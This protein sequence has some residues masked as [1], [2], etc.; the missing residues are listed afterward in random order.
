MLEKIAVGKEIKMHEVV[1]HLVINNLIYLIAVVVYLRVLIK[2]KRII[3]WE[4]APADTRNMI[5]RHEKRINFILKIIIGVG[6]IFGL[7]YS[8]IPFVM[9]IGNIMNQ[10][11]YV[12]EGEVESWNYSD[13]G[14]IE[15]RGVGILC[16][17]T[18]KEI[19]VVI[20]DTGVRK[21]EY[22]RVRY[23]PHTKQGEIM[24]RREMKNE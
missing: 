9:D 23:L 11:Y 5:K 13:E 20:Y 6:V 24:Y 15:E 1:I 7:F 17:E 22:L 10:N 21:G 19:F 18:G 14:N 2:K 12:V 16:S 8:F 4:Q 3:K